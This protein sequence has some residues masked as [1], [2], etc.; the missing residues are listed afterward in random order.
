MFNPLPTAASLVLCY[1][2]MIIIMTVIVPVIYHHSVRATCHCQHSGHNERVY[3][4][5]LVLQ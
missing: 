5:F 3:K 4:D 2:C 1:L